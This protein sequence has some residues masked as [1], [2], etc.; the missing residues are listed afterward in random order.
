MLFKLAWRNLWRNRRRSA[1]VLSSVVLGYAALVFLDALSTGMIHQ[2]VRNRVG[3]HTAHIQIHRAGFLDNQVLGNRIT[4]PDAVASALKE[5][6]GIERTSCRV[7]TFGMLN[8]ASGSAG[9]TLVG[10]EPEA[11]S[12]V[13]Q[14]AELVREG[15]YLTGS[16]REILLSGKVADKLGVRLGDKI[17]GM[18]SGLGGEIGAELFRVVGLFRTY[19]SGFDETHA[20]VDIDD[21]Q[22]MLSLGNG[23]ME[24][25]VLC[26]DVVSKDAVKRSLADSLGDG[27]DVSTYRNL[28]PLLVAQLDVYRQMMWIVYAIVGLAVVLGIVNTML[29]AV[30]ERIREFGVLFSIGMHRGR[31]FT[32]VVLEALI[33]GALGTA[34]GVAAGAA[35][36]APF[37]RSGIDLSM[38]EKSLTSF[39]T[40]AV[41][42]PQLTVAA[43]FSAA[44]V[45]PLV[46]VL[47]A[48]YPGYEAVTL[49]PVEAIRHV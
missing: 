33:L 27:Y 18:A 4:N 24:F 32:M 47:G 17:V 43:L 11:E 37:T 41:I 23:V 5:T 35:V 48:L 21:A 34:L 49:E 7:L 6:P 28:L 10:V 38:F 14:I 19:D 25:A 26:S 15:T 29:M 2:M 8:S 42:Y 1:I 36:T 9:L 20:Y 3:V 31:V 12:Q 13:T 44:A 40:G 22:R 30:Y 45:V 46:S 39:G 16:G